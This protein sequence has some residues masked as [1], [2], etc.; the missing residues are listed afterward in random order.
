MNIEPGDKSAHE[1]EDVRDIGS[2]LI[3]AAQTDFESEPE[4]QNVH[5]WLRE[6]PQGAKY[7][8]R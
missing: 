5:C 4:H 2:C 3:G 1:P 7:R 6:E 8:T